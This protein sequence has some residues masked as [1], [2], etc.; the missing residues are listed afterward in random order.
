M[1]VAPYKRN[2]ILCFVQLRDEKVQK[3]YEVLELHKSTYLSVFKDI[4][5]DVKAGRL[6][7]IIVSCR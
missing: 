6:N 5:A 7:G 3:M 4:F 1:C 2:L